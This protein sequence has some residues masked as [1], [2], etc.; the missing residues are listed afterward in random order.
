MKSPI[1]AA[2]CL[3]SAACVMTP[4]GA[5]SPEVMSA[6]PTVTMS[7]VTTEPILYARDGTP[8][9]AS[10]PFAVEPGED[11]PAHGVQ[12]GE[13]SRMY[14]LELYQ[15]AVDAKEALE[16]EV[17]SMTVDL[18]LAREE[19]MAAQTELEQA[20]AR[21][22]QLEGEVGAQRNEL[23]ELAERLITA[24]IRRLESDKLLLEA[25]IDWA[26]TRSVIESKV[27]GDSGSTEENSSAGG[28]R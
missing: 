5:L 10:G 1:L 19:V 2:T 24:Q 17:R 4:Q 11:G 13:Q 14:L 16:L 9:H 15:E 3:L 20:R 28:D 6:T 25:K 12:R 7:E 23:R 18:Q 22:G 21:I 27:R 8:I 26:R